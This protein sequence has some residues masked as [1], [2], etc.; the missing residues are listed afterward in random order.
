MTAHFIN[1]RNYTIPVWEADI[2]LHLSYTQLLDLTEVWKFNNIHTHTTNLEQ[3]D[4][5]H[6]DRVGCEVD[7]SM[8]SQLFIYHCTCVCSGKSKS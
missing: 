5:K 8:S 7:T 3:L 2:E 1:S 4:R 6:W